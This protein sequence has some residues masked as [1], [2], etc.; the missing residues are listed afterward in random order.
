M[1][2]RAAILATA[3]TVA[4]AGAASAQFLGSPGDGVVPRSRVEQMQGFYGSL[5]GGMNWLQ[6]TDMHVTDWSN[7][8]VG[9]FGFVSGWTANGAVGYAFGIGPRVELE[10]SYRRNH[11]TNSINGGGY[12][13]SWQ[14][15]DFSRLNQLGLMA[16]IAY[17]IYTGTRI[18]PY[19][20]FGAG[21]VRNSLRMRGDAIGTYPD[22]DWG[23]EVDQWRLAVQGFGGV[24]FLL[25]QAIRIGAR[26]TFLHT[27]DLTE[28][29]ID[30]CCW[31][32]GSARLDPNNHSVTLQVAYNFGAPRTIPAPPPSPAAAPA[33]QQIGRAHV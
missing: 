6:S 12:D 9:E 11:F 25:T 7:Y 20:G 32:T 26:Y 4:T 21:A 33:I 18:V 10:L 29:P 3:M 16:N 24:D 5:G 27:R 2:L 28:V 13:G 30:G 17:D 22:G 1:K 8:Y 15:G 14:D 19:L 23:D 31:G